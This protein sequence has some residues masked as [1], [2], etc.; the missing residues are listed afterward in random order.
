MAMYAV[1]A[2][3]ISTIYTNW[4]DVER[5]KALYPYPKWK[6][7]Y[8]E[9]EAHEWLKRNTYGHN[10]NM[11]T[12]YGNTLDDLYV[13]VQYKIFSDSLAIVYD[14]SRV[15]N[16][17]LPETRNI[18][19]YAGDRIHVKVPDIY[20]SELSISSHMSAI[21]NILNLLGDIIDVNIELPNYSVFYSL[22][23]YSKGNLHAISTVQDMVRNRQ[24]A[25]SYTLKLK[26]L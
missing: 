14:T 11:V 4:R 18:V 22:T 17:R 15:G 12:K 21:Y 25:V 19:A 20:L 7:V 6:K 24:G 3:G 2:P 5:I 26:E 1:V 8:N 13:D 16:I 9:Q 10:L 23:G